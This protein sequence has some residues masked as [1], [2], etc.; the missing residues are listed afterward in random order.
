MGFIKF[1]LPLNE[2]DVIPPALESWAGQHEG[3]TDSLSLL[4]THLTKKV[5]EVK[6]DGILPG[7]ADRLGKQW[8]LPPQLLSNSNTSPALLT[9]LQRSWEIRQRLISHPG[10][11]TIKYKFALL[12]EKWEIDVTLVPFNFIVL[13]ECSSKKL[14]HL[15]TSKQAMEFFC[16]L[17]TWNDHA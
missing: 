7:R 1:F 14:R 11:S 2:K 12:K 5:R 9:F 13:S 3:R 10:K 8:S 16:S 6:W 4:Y 17:K 15:V